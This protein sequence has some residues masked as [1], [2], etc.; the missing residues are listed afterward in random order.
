M[1]NY[2]VPVLKTKRTSEK[3][4]C[5]YLASLAHDKII[6]YLEVL[7]TKNE[8]AFISYVKKLNGRPFCAGAYR[9]KG[10]TLETAISGIEEMAARTNT[11]IPAISIVASDLESEYHHATAFINRMHQ[12]KKRICLRFEV[13][14]NPDAIIPVLSMLEPKDICIFDTGNDKI[15]SVFSSNKCAIDA[16]PEGV[17][18]VAFSLERNAER[19][20]SSYALCGDS[21]ALFN[22]DL[23]TFIAGQ[24]DV[25][26]GIASA[27][28]YKDDLTGE[29]RKPG[30]QCYGILIIYSASTNKFFTIRTQ[31]A[32]QV[33]KSY[34][35]LHGDVMAK[36]DTI[37][38][39]FAN[40]PASRALLYSPGKPSVIR[41][42]R[43]GAIHY[44]EEV[45]N[46]YF[47]KT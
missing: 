21:T 17:I 8:P 26:D 6:P 36:K 44:I 46:R 43:I 33:A 3:G 4:V 14:N 24:P 28:T 41:Y 15:S 34:H 31:H 32:H 23:P 18:K 39:M 37:D 9:K 27:C 42:Q 7:D 20:G 12:Q 40:T 30:I 45:V 29:D 2:F 10:V 13:L 16:I 47:P 25:F 1:I 19:A 22:A 11:F 5:E 35:I 38:S